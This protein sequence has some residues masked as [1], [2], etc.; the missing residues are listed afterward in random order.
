MTVYTLRKPSRRT[1]QYPWA[2]KVILANGVTTTF[3]MTQA[4]YGALLRAEE[5]RWGDSPHFL[6]FDSSSVFRVA[7][8]I[9]AATIVQVQRGAGPSFAIETDDGHANGE[10][11]RIW[12]AASRTPIEVPLSPSPVN[13]VR[14]SPRQI[15][16]RDLRHFLGLQE[17]IFRSFEDDEQ[18]EILRVKAD[19]NRTMFFEP[20]HIALIVAPQGVCVTARKKGQPSRGPALN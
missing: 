2:A 19:S 1:E 17:V 18:R 13:V 4:D 7:L 15:H 14:A 9:R 8:N 16:P 5:T 11:V 6:V 12:P 10:N 3:R 20:A